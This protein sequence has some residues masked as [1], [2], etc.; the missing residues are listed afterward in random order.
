M[1]RIIGVYVD[2]KLAKFARGC[3]LLI[4][5]AQYTTEEYLDVFSSKQG[6]G[7]STFEMAVEA[8]NQANAEKL[9]FF[10]FDPAYNDEK[11]DELGAQYEKENMIWNHQIRPT[12]LFV[13]R[14]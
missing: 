2:K 1:T 11:L 12:E 8:K 4:H 7:H 3:D 10:H 9:V 5:D 13:L 6:Y 14:K